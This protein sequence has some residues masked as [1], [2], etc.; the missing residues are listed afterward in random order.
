V[1]DDKSLYK[2][3]VSVRASDELTVVCCEYVE[4][5]GDNDAKHQALLALDRRWKLAQQPERYVV[6]EVE[7]GFFVP[8]KVQP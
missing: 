1:N 4:A 2:V 8:H 7:R 6:R 5:R 3:T